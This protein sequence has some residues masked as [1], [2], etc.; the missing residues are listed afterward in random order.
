M[1][2][3]SW[4]TVSLSTFLVVAACGGRVGDPAPDETVGDTPPAFASPLPPPPALPEE[5]AL[6]IG[7]PSAIDIVGDQIVV[8]TSATRLSNEL[9]NAGALFVADRRLPKPLMLA[10]DRQGASW[11]T[12]ATD[13][14]SAWVGTSDGRLLEVPLRG[15]VPR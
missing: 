10:V 12:L 5:I 8:T 14:G 1:R 2:S 11:D 3:S 6:G 4:M 7:T 9:V 15:G 13:G